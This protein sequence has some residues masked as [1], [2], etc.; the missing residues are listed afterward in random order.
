LFIA[1]YFSVRYVCTDN[2]ISVNAQCTTKDAIDST[3]RICEACVRGDM[4]RVSTDHLK[5]HQTETIRPGQ[6]FTIDCYTHKHVI[7]A[8][9]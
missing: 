7:R 8:G 5:E 4:K 9:N 6:K 1:P 3:Q 2:D